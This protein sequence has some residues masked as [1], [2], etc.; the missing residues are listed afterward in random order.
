M[1][2]YFLTR[3]IKQQRN[4]FVNFMQTQMFP[5]KRKHLKTNK[6]EFVQ[7]QG[8]LRPVEL[9]EYVFPEECLDEVLTMLE[10]N[11]KQNYNEGLKGL[12]NKAKLA[13][14]RKI[15]GASK[16]PKFKPAKTNRYIEKR[17]MAIHAIG[18]RKDKRQ[19]VP[20]WGYE[21]EML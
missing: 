7:V 1:H 4:V 10:I 8:S 11:P 15:L 13:A 14:L 2:L 5:W 3:G 19:K 20:E 16:I 21:Q 9:W 18:I 6:D 17:G 12:G